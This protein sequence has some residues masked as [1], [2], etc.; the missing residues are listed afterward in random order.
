MPY[1]IKL[2]RLDDRKMTFGYR[3]FVNRNVASNVKLTSDN[4][5]VSI[6]FD[7]IVAH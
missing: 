6:N 1:C 3:Q 4:A 7:A 5:A 2:V